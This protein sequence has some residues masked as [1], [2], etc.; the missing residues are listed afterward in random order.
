MSFSSAPQAQGKEWLGFEWKFDTKW[1]GMKTSWKSAPI[2]GVS[3][4]REPIYSNALS[5]VV[6]KKPYSRKNEWTSGVPFENARKDIKRT[7]ASQ[8]TTTENDQSEKYN[9]KVCV[10]LSRLATVYSLSVKSCW[11]LSYSVSLFSATTR[12]G[13][14]KWT[15]VSSEPTDD[16][17]WVRHFFSRP[18]L[19]QG[20]TET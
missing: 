20:P 10:C 16:V 9:I 2:F 7:W 3:S 13:S 14:R 17:L 11:H 5:Q 19:P 18:R 6:V 12:K 8:R 15:Y 1:R 4:A